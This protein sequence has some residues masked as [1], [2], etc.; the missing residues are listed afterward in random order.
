MTRQRSQARTGARRVSLPQLDGGAASTAAP[1]GRNYSRWRVATLVGVHVLAAIHIAHWKLSGKTLAPLEL[2]EV[3]YTLELGIVTAGFLFMALIVVSTMIFGRFFCSWGCHILAL[4]D[5]CAWILRKLRIRAKPVRSRV[6]L[7]VGPGA[8]FYMFIWPALRRVAFDDGRAAALRV[9]D[10]TSGWASFVTDDFWRNLP[11]PGVALL[12]FA[13]CGFVIVYVL[14]T[15]S[16]CRYACPYGAVFGIMDRFAPGRIKVDPDTCTNCGVCTAVCESHVRVHEELAEYGRIV[17]P[18]CLKD[19][20]CVSVCP[21]QALSYGWTRPSL[22]QSLRPGRRRLRYDFTLGEDVLMAVVFLGALAVFRGLYAHVPFLLSLAIGGILA[23][24]AV[25]CLRLWRRPN[26]RLNSFQLKLKGRITRHGAAFTC[27]AALLWVFTAHSAFIRAHE[28]LGQRAAERVTSMYQ[29]GA[30]P[31]SVRFA[32]RAA[33][34]HFELLNRWGLMRPR[35]RFAQMASLYWAAGEVAA[36]ERCWRRAIERSPDNQD[37]RLDLAASLARRGRID[38]AAPLLQ[39]V[40]AAQARSEQDAARYAHYRA[41]AWHRLG[42]IHAVNGRLSEAQSAYESAIAERPDHIAAHLALAELHA[43]SGDLDGARAR[44][45]SA[46]DVDA[47]NVTLL[48]NLAVLDASAGDS[49]RAV[50]GYRRAAEL[51]PADA[52][53]WNNLGVALRETGQLLQAGRCFRHALEINADHAHAHF[54]LG[55]LQLRTGRR[56]EGRRH[57]ERAAELDPRYRAFLNEPATS[58]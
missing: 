3:M 25:L 11:G 43:N 38:Q 26:V 24:L 6:L 13:I 42:T 46:L 7:L 17:D 23:Y 22:L 49:D 30:E 47:D 56:A 32:A 20:D 48:Y 54:N 28:A 36:A 1:R 9:T 50:A 58:P 15:R 29:A 14:G 16:F 31:A 37:A 35:G 5:L 44:L 21:E 51:R 45:R 52:D 55:R 18:A 27:F 12:T 10:D 33:I 41:S 8:L 2:N 39:Q 40:T 4:Q 19:L 34:D 53:I 57:L